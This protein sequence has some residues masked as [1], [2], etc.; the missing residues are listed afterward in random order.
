MMSDYE[1]ERRTTSATATACQK[2]TEE[3][4]L[5]PLADSDAVGGEDIFLGSARADFNGIQKEI[6]VRT[7]Y[8]LAS[9]ELRVP[10]V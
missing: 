2:V 5:P 10:S 9:P 4:R 1:A 7:P 3:S 6:E 8:T